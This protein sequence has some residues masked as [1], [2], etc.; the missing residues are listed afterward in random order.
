[1]H[2]TVVLVHE[3]VTAEK[4][5]GIEG[6]RVNTGRELRVVLHSL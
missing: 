1:M 3:H 5:N 4:P 6:E 2:V